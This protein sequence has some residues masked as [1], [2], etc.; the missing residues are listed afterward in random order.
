MSD[1]E[2]LKR[3]ETAPPLER[4]RDA[5]RR[6]HKADA[7]RALADHVGGS[8][9]TNEHIKTLYEALD[10]IE[11]RADRAAG[12]GSAHAK[13]AIREWMPYII[14]ARACLEF[15]WKHREALGRVEVNRPHVT[16]SMPN[17]ALA[18]S[19]IAAPVYANEIHEWFSV[20]PI[21]Q[22]GER[23]AMIK[24]L[25]VDQWLDEFSGDHEEDAAFAHTVF[26]ERFD[27]TPTESERET[28]YLQT[29]VAEMRRTGK[30][31]SDERMA[32]I[33]ETVELGESPTI[34]HPPGFEWDVRQDV[35]EATPPGARIWAEMDR[36]RMVRVNVRETEGAHIADV[37]VHV[38]SACD[39]GD[40]ARQIA[41]ALYWSWWR[42][43]RMKGL[44]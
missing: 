35:M 20:R 2:R 8:G 29:V 41:Q 25:R 1:A 39:L 11:M 21:P 3:D 34:E 26:S 10:N 12:V 18:P 32:E 43:Q 6:D 5:L 13:N 33:R 28:A 22:S 44:L 27:Y 31:V 14:D 37:T 7:A 15:E 4:L 30:A 9:K 42:A 40:E 17:G 23:Y 36:E 24:A 38:P 19:P 16:K